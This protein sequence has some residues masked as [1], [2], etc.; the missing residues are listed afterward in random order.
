[1]DDSW[2][3]EEAL[4]PLSLINSNGLWRI[5]HPRSLYI[6]V[7]CIRIGFF[8]ASPCTLLTAQSLSAPSLMYP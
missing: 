3:E 8:D 2:E 4:S 5:V 6:L 1:M 7:L